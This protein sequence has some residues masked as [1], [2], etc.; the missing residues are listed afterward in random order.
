MGADAGARLEQDGVTYCARHPQTETVLR[1][2][3]CGTP[4][5]PR[6]LVQTPVG[7]RCRECAKVSRLPTLTLSPAYLARGAAAAL[8]T[9]AVVGAAWGYL[10]GDRLIIGYLIILIIGLAVGWPIAE[11]VGAATNQKRGPALQACAVVGVVLAYVV[12]NLVA[13]EALLPRRDLANQLAALIA[14]GWAY[15]RLRGP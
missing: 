3:R 13:G 1:C 15:F 6:C 12:H 9:G 7:A 11:A 8:L 10:L 4:I 5:C 2:G 14:A